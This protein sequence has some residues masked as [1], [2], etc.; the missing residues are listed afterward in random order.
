[1][2]QHALITVLAVLTGLLLLVPT[3][4]CVFAFAL[5]AQYTETFLGELPCKMERLR[6]AEGPRIILVGGSSVPFSIKS[7][8]IEASFPEYTAVDFGL[9]AELGTPIM[10]DWLEEEL[11]EGDLV[12]ISPE[13]D[14]QA[15]SAYFSGESVWQAVDGSFSLL[16]RLS[17]DR[18]EGLLAALPVFAGK[19]CRYFLDGSPQPNDIYA[20]ASFNRYGDIDSPLRKANIMAG[21]YDPNQSI[22]FSTDVIS[23]DFLGLLNQFA[24]LCQEK[25]AEVYYR[26]PPMNRAALED[27]SEKTVDRY[28]DFLRQQLD[29][30]ILGDPHRSILESGWFYDTNFHL[31]GS[32]ATIFTRYL[33]EDLK[34][35]WKDTSPTEIAVPPMPE[36]AVPGL[37][38][39]DNSCVDCFTYAQAQGGWIISGLTEKG[40]TAQALIL[41]VSL[42][43]QSVVGIA[44]DA[45]TG[46][47]ALRE[48][49]IQENIG[50]LYDGMFSG[51][52]RL[53]K[54]ILTGES[55]SAYTVGDGLLEGAEF[56]ICVKA[57]ALDSYRRHYS[58]Q[59]YSAYLIA[60]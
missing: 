59:R 26:F 12:I 60:Q 18:Y 53:E 35:L 21:G 48:V 47:A 54:V 39:G 14:S 17:P 1:M 3:V 13:Q 46:A 51:C 50:T 40:L 55:P 20:R 49:T 58:W 7:E 19:K 57:S 44:A 11:R 8:L 28:Y 56:L 4:L 30:P 32:G 24:A 16:K 29:F 52:A 34:L 37:I 10:L 31:N 5:P 36:P 42:E 2:K 38:D 25:G 9:Y 41:P 22:S 6:N 15:L 23:G 43:G 33:I 45:L 27:A